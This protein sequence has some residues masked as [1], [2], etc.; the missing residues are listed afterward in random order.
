MKI[1]TSLIRFYGM[2]MI[3]TGLIVIGLM[4]IILFKDSF[5]S[6]ADLSA[7]PSKVDIAEPQLTLIDLSGKTV[8]L[9]DHLGKVV[10]VNLWATWCPPCKQEMPA[11]QKFYDTYKSK[12]FDLLA[13]DQEESSK[14]VEPFVRDFGLTFPIWLD[15]NYLAQ[16]VFNTSALPSSYVIDRKGTIR[17]MWIGAISIK[18]LEQYVPDLIRS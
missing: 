13:I 2:L 1:K 9:Q 7:I 5:N 11:L 12:G 4:L 15:E 3:G 16:R 18:Y 8:S 17:L 14:V 6:P 10:L